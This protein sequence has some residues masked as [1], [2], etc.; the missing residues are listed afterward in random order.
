L[1][2]LSLIVEAHKGVLEEKI[3]AWLWASSF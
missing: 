2:L 1:P 3:A